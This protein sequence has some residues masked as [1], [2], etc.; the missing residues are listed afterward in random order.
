[1]RENRHCLGCDALR[2][3]LDHNGQ[4]KRGG[5]RDL[6]PIGLD[7]IDEVSRSEILTQLDGAVGKP[8]W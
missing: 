5:L 1:M 7:E 2:N 4:M 6:T 8:T 3:L